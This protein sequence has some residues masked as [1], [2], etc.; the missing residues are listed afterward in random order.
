M[1]GNHTTLAGIMM[2]AIRTPMLYADPNESPIR[3]A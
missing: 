3:D 2:C 1:Y